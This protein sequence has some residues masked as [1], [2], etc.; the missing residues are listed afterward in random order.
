MPE[1]LRRIIRVRDLPQWTG[2]GRTRNQELIASG[3]LPK[4]FLLTENGRS[5]GLFED[6]LIAW[7]KRRSTVTEAPTR[8]HP[9]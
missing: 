2:L 3:E 6:D 4:P 8:R 7:Q 5:K 9:R 1:T